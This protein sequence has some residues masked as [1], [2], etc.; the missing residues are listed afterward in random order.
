MTKTSLTLNA[1]EIQALLVGLSMA[2]A[3]PEDWDAASSDGAVEYEALRDK[4]IKALN[5]VD[6]R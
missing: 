3:T 1:A 2:G 5:K 4:I 6:P